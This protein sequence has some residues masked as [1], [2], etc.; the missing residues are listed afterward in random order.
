VKVWDKDRDT[1]LRMAVAAVEASKREP[2]GLR[3]ADAKFPDHG[4]RQSTLD[5]IGADGPTGQQKG[6]GMMDSLCKC[7]ACKKDNPF[8]AWREDTAFVAKAQPPNSVLRQRALV[9]MAITCA[10]CGTILGISRARPEDAARPSPV[11]PR[12]E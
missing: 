11:P 6:G 2:P 7:P 4:P 10:S 12:G 1:A 9:V 5:G 3:D 8:L